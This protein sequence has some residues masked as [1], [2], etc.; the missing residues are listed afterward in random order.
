MKLKPERRN[1]IT[2]GDHEFH[3][4]RDV[5]AVMQF[6]KTREQLRQMCNE[7]LPPE[8]A[9]SAPVFD[10]LFTDDSYS[11]R[12]SHRYAISMVVAQGDK[13]EAALV[14]AK[15]QQN[16]LPKNL[17]EL[18]IVPGSSQGGICMNYEHN[19]SIP[20]AVSLKRAGYTP[21]NL[22]FVT[23]TG[24]TARVVERPSKVGDS[25]FN[26]RSPGDKRD[27]HIEGKLNLIEFLDKGGR[28]RVECPACGLIPSILG[29][30]SKSKRVGRLLKLV[31]L[32]NSGS[33]IKVWLEF[34]PEQ[35]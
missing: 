27:S 33:V 12:A 18:V 25:L 15:W 19:L 28:V 30:G 29:L 9:I 22:A 7:H 6:G 11:V 24:H 16:Y 10:K 1:I 32:D 2:D 31:E 5:M 13:R 14:A 20:F 4:L 17:A 3:V 35:H 26:V 23:S 8:E 21:A 34:D